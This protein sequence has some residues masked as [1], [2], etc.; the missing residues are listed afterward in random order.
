VNEIFP[1]QTD[2]DILVELP[3]LWWITSLQGLNRECLDLF[4]VFKGV[5]DRAQMVARIQ[6]NSDLVVELARGFVT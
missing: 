5:S 6:I 3:P 2:Q 4:S 1:S